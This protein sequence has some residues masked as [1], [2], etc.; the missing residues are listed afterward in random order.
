MPTLTVLYWR[1]IPSQVIVRRGRTK[2]RVRLSDRFQEAIDR[3]AMRAGRGASDAYLADWR[4][5]EPRPCGEDLQA[6]ADAEAAR[7]EAS[8]DDAT[9][10]VLIRRHGL[11]DLLSGS[12]DSGD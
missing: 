8:L 10:A 4:R 7:L 12:A 6:E 9:L 3:A 11:A 5:S 1:D 2:A